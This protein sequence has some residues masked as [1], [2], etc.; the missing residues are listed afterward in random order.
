MP[1][2]AVRACRRDLER[3][4]DLA[5]YTTAASVADLDAVREALGYETINLIGGSYGTRLAMEYARSHPRRVRTVVLEGPVPPSVR[6][7]GRF[8]T[9]A[10][11]SLDAVLDGC[12][13]TPECAAAF[14]NIQAEAVTVFDRLRKGP[15]TATVVHPA[16]R[17]TTRVTL[18]RDHVA[19][20]LRYML[21]TSGG[22]L[23]VPLVLHAASEGDFGPMA[24]FLMQRRADGTFDALY[25]SVTCTE[26]V[27]F[28]PTDAE[29][30]DEPTFLGDYRVRQQRAA[31]AEWPR[32]R[33]PDT[34]G[35]PVV[36]RAPVL[37]ISGTIDPATPPEFGDEIA[38]TLTNSRHVRV[39]FGAHSP[40]GL[41]G[42]DC[43]DSIRATFIELADT[44]GLDV[45]CV[46][47]ISRPPFPTR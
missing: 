16:G 26:D 4:A 3:V 37:I 10:Q 13:A 5:Q 21:Y 7:P 27:P 29:I 34:H 43:L 18:T 42:L 15:V 40:N 14:P 2:E 6:M 19:E 31:C 36:S 32:G 28:L 1:L 33:V 25:L 41:V 38:R 45:G 47:S 30:V 23:R 46:G 17:K 12:L 9:Y 11:R 8:G 39:P 24:R 44:A 35:A 20:A 22:A